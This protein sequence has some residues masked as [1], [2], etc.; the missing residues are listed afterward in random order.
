MQSSSRTR[1]WLLNCALTRAGGANKDVLQKDF[2]WILRW[3]CHHYHWANQEMV[4]TRPEFLRASVCDQWHVFIKH[5][6]DEMSLELIFVEMRCCPTQLVSVIRGHF[7]GSGSIQVSQWNW[8]PFL[9]PDHGCPKTG[10]ADEI[11]L[12]NRFPNCSEWAELQ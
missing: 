4:Q 11:S 1:H 2:A 5:L 6:T 8:S 12:E 7:L 10:N 9:T 3:G